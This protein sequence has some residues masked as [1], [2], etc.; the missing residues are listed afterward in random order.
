MKSYLLLGL[1]VATAT[2]ASADPVDK[3]TH[4]VFF[5]IDIDG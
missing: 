3:V 2:I 4:K 1:L 5:D